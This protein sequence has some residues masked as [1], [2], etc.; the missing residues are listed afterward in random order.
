MG[1]V[2][3]KGKSFVNEICKYLVLRVIW[4]E[5]DF[6]SIIKIMLIFIGVVLKFGFF[7]L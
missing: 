2:I 1:Y 6:I 7:F 3:V 4:C 5:N